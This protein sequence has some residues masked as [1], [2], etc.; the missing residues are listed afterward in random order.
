MI[1]EA[2]QA[3][4][5]EF[6]MLMQRIDEETDFML[7]E[8]GERKIPEKML[9]GMIDQFSK[10]DNSVILVAQKD[11]SLVGYLLADGGK[12]RRNGHCVYIVIGIRK[13]Y[14]GN[15]IGTALF[16]ELESWAAA[17][18]VHRLELTVL[19]DNVPGRKLYEK[20]GFVVEG[21]RRDSLRID[22]EYRDEIYMGK[23]LEGK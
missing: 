15:G 7:Y 12:A 18:E 20:S 5:A 1:R 10:R 23:L 9:N 11:M 13:A 8:P 2:V 16:R 4:A 14:R 3:D 17:K 19:A 6:A 21:I 22:G